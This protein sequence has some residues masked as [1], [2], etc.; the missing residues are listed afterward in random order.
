MFHPNS[1]AAGD[2]GDIGAVRMGRYKV[3]YY[4]LGVLRAADNPLLPLANVKM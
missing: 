1:G 2:I 4:T 3:V